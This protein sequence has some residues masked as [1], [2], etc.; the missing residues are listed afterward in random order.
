ML[1]DLMLTGFRSIE[2]IRHVSSTLPDVRILA[3]SP[4]DPSNDRV[5]LAIQ[6]G[7][8][9]YV[10]R[11]AESAGTNAAAFAAGEIRPG[12]PWVRLIAGENIRYVIPQIVNVGDEATLSVRVREPSEKVRLRV[13]NI[14]TKG[15]RVVKPSQVVQ[16][17]IAA[18]DW[19]KMSGDVDELV[20]NC[21]GRG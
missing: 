7:A 6:A 9:G 17:A 8:L 16:V 18:K 20:I 19:C 21:A 14:L 15:L 5:I 4:G 13:G 2:V 1:V 12:K 3:L 10:T 11:E